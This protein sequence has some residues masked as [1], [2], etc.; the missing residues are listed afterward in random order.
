MEDGLNE[1]LS[2][3]AAR[4]G[5]RHAIPSNL[6]ASD[7]VAAKQLKYFDGVINRLN[8]TVNHLCEVEARA[9]GLNGRIN[10]YAVDQCDSGIPQDASED[11]KTQLDNVLTRLETIVGA[12][13]H[14]VDV[15]DN[16][17]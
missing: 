7:A 2:K 17:A 10:G 12:V 3:A 4:P 11:A 15:L 9:R 14:E 13:S 5:P 16:L 1:R 6:V 8:L